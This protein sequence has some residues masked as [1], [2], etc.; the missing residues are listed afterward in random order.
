MPA[1]ILGRINTP[2]HLIHAC[3]TAVPPHTILP[4]HA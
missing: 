4:R 2:I 1:D 3:S